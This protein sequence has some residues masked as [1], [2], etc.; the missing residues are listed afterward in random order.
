MFAPRST[1]TVPVRLAV[2]VML[3]ILV[4]E[5]VDAAVLVRVTIAVVMATAFVHVAVTV[6]RTVLVRV[7]IA[8][9]VATAFILVAI[10]VTRAIL[11]RVAVAVPVA[12]VAV[13][14]LVLVAPTIVRAVVPA[15]AVLVVRTRQAAHEAA[16]TQHQN[17]RGVDDLVRHDAPPMVVDHRL[18]NILI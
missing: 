12:A 17:E 3:A 14:V 10:T 1:G 15:R 16:K 4:T 13:V 5:P 7:A 11:V 18:S 9:R 2:G 8:V 6:T